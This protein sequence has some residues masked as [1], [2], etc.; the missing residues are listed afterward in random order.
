MVWHI[1]KKD[2]RLLWPMSLFVV[3]AA[4]LCAL[5]T[6]LLGF[7]DQPVL[8]R[9]TFFLPYL[10]YLGVVI[11]AVAVVQ[12]EALSDPQ[13][14]WLI[15][16]IRRRDLVLSK[17]LFVLLTVNV[18]LMIVDAVQQLALHVPLSVSIGVAVSRA[19]VMVFVFS[20][21]ALVLGAVTRSLIDAFVFGIVS[22]IGF[23]FLVMFATSALSPAYSARRFGERFQ[24]RFPFRV[25]NRS[26][27]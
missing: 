15:R 22:A 6:T 18:P 5:R 17:V 26:L 23:A 16:P 19:L 25:A 7:F 1:F 4:A 12:Q 14:D 9:L 10:V 20:L 27:E 21:P 13:E 11:V 3:V 24:Q 2:V 8:D